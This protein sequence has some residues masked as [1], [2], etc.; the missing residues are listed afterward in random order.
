[1]AQ[2]ITFWKMEGK[3]DIELKAIRLKSKADI[4]K[5]MLQMPDETDIATLDRTD[6]QSIIMH[7]IWQRKS[8]IPL[9][10]R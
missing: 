10:E 7:H 6:R 8:Y 5:A 4:P 1:M 3:S 2:R 9:D